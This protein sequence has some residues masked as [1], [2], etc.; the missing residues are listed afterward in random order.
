MYNGRSAS[1]GVH[2]L[3]WLKIP[4][5]Y[6]DRQHVG[7]NAAEEPNHGRKGHLFPVQARPL[8]AVAGGG[9]QVESLS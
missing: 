8:E 7:G 9:R 2:Q 5:F 3:S 1:R 4:S 6:V